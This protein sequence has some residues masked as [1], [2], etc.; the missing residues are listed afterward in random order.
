MNTHENTVNQYLG[1]KNA[2]H[3]FPKILFL[4]NC[5]LM[6]NERVFSCEQ[7]VSTNTDLN[8]IYQHIIFS[9]I[10]SKE[11]SLCHKL[12]FSNT[13]IFATQFRRPQICQTMNFVRSNSLSLKYQGF[14]TIRLQRYMDQKILI[15][16]KNSISLFFFLFSAKPSLFCKKNFDCSKK[17]S[18]VPL[19]IS[20]VCLSLI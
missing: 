17:T 7:F 15:G 14:S 12:R 6:H 19:N 18:T 13:Y 11:L 5:M 16:G 3:A 8:K 20:F 4:P 1:G 10:K 2:K 9:W